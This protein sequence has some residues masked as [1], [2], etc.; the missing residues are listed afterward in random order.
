MSLKF[1]NIVFQLYNQSYNNIVYNNNNQIINNYL[2]MA[3]VQ[4]I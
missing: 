1:V 4:F 2:L 3:T